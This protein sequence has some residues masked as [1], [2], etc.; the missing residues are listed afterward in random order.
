VRFASTGDAVAMPCPAAGTLDDIPGWD[1]RGAGKP[2]APRRLPPLRVHLPRPARQFKGLTLHAMHCHDC[3]APQG[4]GQSNWPALG[5][6]IMNAITRNGQYPNCRHSRRPARRATRNPQAR[7]GER[8]DA[9]S[10]RPG[11][12]G[13]SC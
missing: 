1:D 3:Q 8:V 9:Q 10:G 4:P 13:P 11:G 7:N 2:Q 5:K 6:A 12:L